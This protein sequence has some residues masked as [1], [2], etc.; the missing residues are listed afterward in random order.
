MLMLHHYDKHLTVHSIAAGK[1]KA[2]RAGTA[3]YWL[4]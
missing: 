2:H 3:L 1:N 4:R